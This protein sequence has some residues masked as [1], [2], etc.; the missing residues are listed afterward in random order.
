MALAY[1]ALR[2]EITDFR[3]M[4]SDGYVLTLIYMPNPDDEEL[5][6]RVI[7]TC[8]A[9]FPD[10][11]EHS[12]FR[13]GDPPDRGANKRTRLGF[14]FERPLTGWS[15]CTDGPCASCPHHPDHWDVSRRTD[16]EE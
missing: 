5:L 6:T 9:A 4:T 2:G 13:P 12:V 15:I 11:F 10:I 14:A 7:R 16:K 3:S 1:A 8:M